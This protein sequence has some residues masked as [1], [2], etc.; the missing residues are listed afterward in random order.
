[1]A[2]IGEIARD[3]GLSPVTCP[4]CG[5]R[6]R[7]GVRIFEGFFRAIL[8]RVRAGDEVKVN[9]FGMFYRTVNLG[10]VLSSGMTRRVGSRVHDAGGRKFKATARIRFKQARSAKDFINR[11]GVR[12]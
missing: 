5:R 11:K 4:H 7:T 10:R 8:E 9:G 6:I 12:P 3:A 2:G 1:M